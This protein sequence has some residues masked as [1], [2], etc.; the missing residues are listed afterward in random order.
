MT[1][2]TVYTT[3]YYGIDVVYNDGFWFLTTCAG[4][5]DCMGGEFPNEAQIARFAQEHKRFF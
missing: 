3:K 4:V 2:G 1:N 5:E